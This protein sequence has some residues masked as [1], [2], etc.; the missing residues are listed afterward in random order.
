MLSEYF[1]SAIASTK[2]LRP[3]ANLSES[4]YEWS[5]TFVKKFACSHSSAVVFDVGAGD[6][7][8]REPVENAGLEWI[9]FD[10]HP[11]SD[12]VYAWDLSESC[13]VQDKKANLIL[14]LDVIEHLV[15]PGI[16][17][18]NI[19]NVLH[20]DGVILLSMPNPRWSRSRTF[21]LITGDLSCF[22]PHDLYWNHHVF[23]PWPH[24]LSKLL[25]DAGFTIEEYFTLDGKTS[26]PSPSLSLTFLPLCLEAAG[27]KLLERW[28]P[29]ACGLSYA[30]VAR[31]DRNL[32]PDQ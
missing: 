31:L 5:G 9:G 17:L 15:N 19:S 6:C 12:Q 29:S 32:M 2:R 30:L 8:L 10:L 28:D 23:P 1:S 20:P 18:R 25:K 7:P 26:W 16:A 3:Q 22:T 11:T 24:V 21:H 27:C 14:M 13:P 4:R